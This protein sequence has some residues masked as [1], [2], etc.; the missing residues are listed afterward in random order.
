VTPD[1]TLLLRWKDGDRQA[2]SELLRRYFE[3]LYRFFRSKVDRGVDELIQQTLVACV[4][5]R[6][7]V[8]S[9]HGFRAFLYGVARNQLFVHFRRAR[10]DAAPLDAEHQSVAALGESPSAL[11]ARRAEYKA[12]GKAL[13]RIPLDYQILLELF[14][15]EE[16]TGPELASVLELSEGTVRTRLRRGRQLLLEQLAAMSEGDAAIHTTEADLEEWVRAVRA[17]VAHDPDPGP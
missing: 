1:E 16:L 12:L 11:V 17:H 5:A 7:R 14:Y 15:W 6:D 13:R 8:Q 10:K 2:G 9:T 4:D 3:P